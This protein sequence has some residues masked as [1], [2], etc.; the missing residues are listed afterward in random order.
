MHNYGG[1]C[2]AFQEEDKKKKE[3]DEE[4]KRQEV[5][6]HKKQMEE[7]E[8]K[9]KENDR[10]FSDNIDMDDLSNMDEFQNADQQYMQR[11]KQK[12][13]EQVTT[14]ATNQF[15]KFSSDQRMNAVHSNSKMTSKQVPSS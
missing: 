11:N 8:K 1:E 5:A 13:N 4:R 12:L 3:A 6:R 2:Q 10:H 14:Q 9:K 15:S 7:Y